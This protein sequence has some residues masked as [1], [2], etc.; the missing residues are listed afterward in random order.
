MKTE[1]NKALGVSG[2]EEM[3]CGFEEGAREVDEMLD[4]FGMGSS[5]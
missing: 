4:L 3:V 1:T 2:G 5:M